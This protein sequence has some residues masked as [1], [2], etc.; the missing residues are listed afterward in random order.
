MPR[1]LHAFLASDSPARFSCLSTSEDSC[2]TSLS[3]PLLPIA[4]RRTMC[5]LP[6]PME[7]VSA[8]GRFRSKPPP[9]RA[10]ASA[11]RGPTR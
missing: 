2:A 11:I 6:R 10:S 5:L 1:L 9:E 8:E 4:A 3:S 7:G